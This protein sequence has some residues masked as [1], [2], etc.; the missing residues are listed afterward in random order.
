[1]IIIKCKKYAW[2]A[3]KKDDDRVFFLKQAD[4]KEELTKHPPEILEAFK[5]KKEYTTKIITMK[6][7][8]VKK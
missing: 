5:A 6:A 2:V 3:F 7:R 8:I 4:T 1:M